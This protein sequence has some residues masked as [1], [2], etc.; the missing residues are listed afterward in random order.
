M[1]NIQCSILKSNDDLAYDLQHQIA[2][3]ISAQFFRQ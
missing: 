1:S 3:S 2:E